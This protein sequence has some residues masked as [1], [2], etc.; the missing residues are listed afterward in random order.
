MID[1]TQVLHVAALARLR[2]EGDEVDAMAGE[3]STILDHIE[4]ISKL[5]LDGVEP[6]ARIVDPGNALRADEP[7]ESL[8]RE[9]ILAQAPAVADD[10]FLVPS[11]QST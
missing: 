5:E 4:A 9:T 1:N 10:G 11:P 7:H 6:T 8:S 3:L 2:L